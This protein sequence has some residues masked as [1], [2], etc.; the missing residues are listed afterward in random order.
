[1]KKYLLLL[2]ILLTPFSFASELICEQETHSWVTFELRDTQGPFIY[3]VNASVLHHYSSVRDMICTGNM[4]EDASSIKCAGFY[5]WND[6][7]LE[8]KLIME[9]GKLFALW[10]TNEG[11]GDQEFKTECKFKE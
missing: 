3:P 8:I 5:A 7:L 9:D 11:Y 10:N 6:E 4:T 2:A 1:M